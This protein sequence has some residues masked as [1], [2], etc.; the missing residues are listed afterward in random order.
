REGALDRVSAVF[1]P[2]VAAARTQ[3][4]GTF[5]PRL[6]SAYLYGSIPPGTAVPGVSDPDLLALLHAQALGAARAAARAVEAALD[7]AFAQ[8]D[9]A[10][11]VLS[12]TASTLS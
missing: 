2:V 4:T 11:V 8:I 9:G 7:H 6:H 3:I 10:G 12:S 1:P 5:G